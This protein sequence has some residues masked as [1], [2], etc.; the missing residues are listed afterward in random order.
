MPEVFSKS[1][2]FFGTSNNVYDETSVV[3]EGEDVFSAD[4]LMVTKNWTFEE[5]LMA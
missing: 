1:K 5:P 4:S 3:D 2:G